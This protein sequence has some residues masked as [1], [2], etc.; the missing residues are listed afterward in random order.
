MPS[1]LTVAQIAEINKLHS[2]NVD[3]VLTTLTDGTT[4]IRVVAGYENVVHNGNTY[5][6]LPFE[7]SPPDEVEGENANARIG[8]SD[9]SG[10][11]A[12]LVR[13]QS[14]ID[15]T[16]EFINYNP[17]NQTTSTI[18]LFPNFTIGSADWDW[19][20]TT[21]SFRR[22]NEDEFAF[23]ADTQDSTSIPGYP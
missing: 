22:N 4:T 14:T 2:S 15:A 3:L 8:I 13:Q 19:T 23:P 7:L 12:Q 21:M 17:A 11:I 18:A 10:Q 1:N 16:F 20:V 9:V 5:T 6:A